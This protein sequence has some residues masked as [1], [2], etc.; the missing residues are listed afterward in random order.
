M[1]ALAQGGVLAHAHEAGLSELV[2]MGQRRPARAT[3]IL[4]IW[5]ASCH[6][7][8]SGPGPPLGAKMRPAQAHGMSLAFGSQEGPTLAF[9]Q[10]PQAG[11]QMAVTYPLGAAQKGRAEGGLGCFW[12]HL[13]NRGPGPPPSP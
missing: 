1:G 3:R 12:P 11:T 2:W 7:G 10:N 8:E 4:S 9:A 6:P 13:D 5:P